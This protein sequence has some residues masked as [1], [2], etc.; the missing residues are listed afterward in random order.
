L[1]AVTVANGRT[2]GVMHATIEPITNKVTR[3][4]KC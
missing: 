2:A 1:V 4:N 3:K